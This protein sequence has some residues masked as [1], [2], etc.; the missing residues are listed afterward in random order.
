MIFTLNR[1]KRVL[2][3]RGYFYKHLYISKIYKNDF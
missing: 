1:Y 3:V 2:S